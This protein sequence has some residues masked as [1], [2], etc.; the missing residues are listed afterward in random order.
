MSRVAEITREDLN[1]DGQCLYDEI[2]SARGSIAGPFRVW[3]HSA[4]FTRRATQLGEFLRYQTSLPARSSELVILITSREQQCPRIWAIHEPIARKAGLPGDIIEALQTDQ[5]PAF[6][7][8]TEAALYDLC[9]QLHRTHTAEEPVM[10]ECVFALGSK[11][12]VEVVGLCGYY[13][14]VAMTLNGFAVG[15]D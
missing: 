8:P 3:L 14:M 9:T 11:A 1:A 7:D 5:R 12:A 13:T 2:L 15:A 6:V 4:E 10:Q